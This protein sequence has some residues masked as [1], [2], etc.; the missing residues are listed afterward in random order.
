M[1][2]RNPVVGGI[3]SL[4]RS[5]DKAFERARKNSRINLNYPEQ[6]IVSRA[7]PA[8]Q[9]VLDLSPVTPAIVPQA[10]TGT[11][12]RLDLLPPETAFPGTQ[13]VQEAP[14][15]IESLFPP[16]P[17]LQ[18]KIVDIPAEIR[19]RIE[20]SPKVKAPIPEAIKSIYETITPSVEYKDGKPYIRDENG[21]LRPYT[22]VLTEG[23]GW[24]DWMPDWITGGEEAPP[25]EVLEDRLTRERGGVPMADRRREHPTETGV[26]TTLP[27]DETEPPTTAA[28]EPPALSPFP[29]TTTETATGALTL[30]QYLAKMKE[31]YPDLDFSNPKQAEADA[32]ARRDLDRT[33]MLAQLSMAAGMVKGAG[34]SWQ[35]IGE[36]F[37]GAGGAYDK[38]FQKYQ[39]ALQD[40]ADRYGKQQE[41]QMTYDTARRKAALD[42]WTTTE[43]AARE[44]QRSIW[45]EENKR[46]WDYWKVG[47]ENK[48]A[49]ATLSHQDIRDYFSKDLEQTKPPS[50]PSIYSPEELA[51]RAKKHDA[52]MRAMQRSFI[53][54]E[55]VRPEDT[56]VDVTGS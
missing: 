34:A 39:Q 4:Q 6:R 56:D 17:R 43:Q 19:K 5:A 42:M 8:P 45:S 26:P 36:G 13:I 55:V 52:I 51:E 40:S 1:A 10:P 22:S 15:F 41:V 49:A 38:G 11:G 50:D 27:P 23:P 47:Q 14:A 25:T 33:A 2:S 44:D 35:G 31:V 18:P 24:P 30:D 48:R 7:L 46:R 3:R 37:A 28:E 21:T 53:R 20:Q 32:N 9:T 54:G 12:P 29:G 16:D